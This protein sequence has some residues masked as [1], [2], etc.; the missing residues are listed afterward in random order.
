MQKGPW[1]W[2]DPWYG[3][4]E[5][6]GHISEIV[7]PNGDG[8]VANMATASVRSIDRLNPTSVLKIRISHSHSMPMR[9]LSTY[10]DH[11]FS[12]IL[13]CYRSYTQFEICL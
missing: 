1:S 12:E 11:S 13:Q 4:L 9:M 10:Y 7:Y 5:S 2:L 3:D 6:I 8:K